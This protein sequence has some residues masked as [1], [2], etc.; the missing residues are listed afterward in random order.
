MPLSIQVKI[1]QVLQDK[2]FMRVGGTSTEKVDVR[3]IAATNRDLREEIANGTFREDLFYRLNVIEINLP[4][5]RSRSEDILLWL[6]CLSK[7]ITVYLAR[8]LLG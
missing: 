7:N 8:I 4:P 5:L 6:K 2:Q 1:L 3:I